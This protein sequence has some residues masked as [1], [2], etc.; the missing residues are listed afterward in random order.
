MPTRNEKEEGGRGNGNKR[1]SF[2]ELRGGALEKQ[3]WPWYL[4]DCLA[5]IRWCFSNNYHG[6]TRKGANW[7]PGL[8]PLC[9]FAWL[10]GGN[11]RQ[12]RAILCPSPFPLIG[13]PAREQGCAK[14]EWMKQEISQVLDSLF[15]ICRISLHLNNEHC[16]PLDHILTKLKPWTNFNL[17]DP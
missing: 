10:L 2:K 9:T 5:S 3:R 16:Q 8:Q 7:L 1:N 11:A 6:G 4:S 14:S 12:L 13:N 15:I 17:A